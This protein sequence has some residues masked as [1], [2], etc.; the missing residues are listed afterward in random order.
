MFGWD[1]RFG[2]F[3]RCACRAG[4]AGTCLRVHKGK[5]V[6]TNTSGV[7]ASKGLS[8]TYGKQLNCLVATHLEMFPQFVVF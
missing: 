2:K 4:T 3:K 5:H 6:S 8:T 1:F 7:S